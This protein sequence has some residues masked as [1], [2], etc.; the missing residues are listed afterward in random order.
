VQGSNYA[1]GRCYQLDFH[2]QG[3]DGKSMI[4]Q[5]I[6]QG[7]DVAGDQ[8]DVLIPGGGVGQFN[9][10]SA[11]WGTSDLGA[12]YGGFLQNCSTSGNKAQCV[13]Q[14]CQQVFA[15][16]PDLMAGCNWFTTWYNTAD[17]PSVTYKQTSCPAAITAKSGLQG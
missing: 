16:K 1:C 5:V 13:Q 15:N 4:V 17:N 3:L 9:A 14:K 8:F 10:C 12:Q 11:Q 6:N 2:G 7:G